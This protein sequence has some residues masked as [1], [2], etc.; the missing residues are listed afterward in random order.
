LL[1]SIFNEMVTTYQS[2]VQG[3]PKDT[4]S[5]SQDTTKSITP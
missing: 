5:D 2:K 3:K 4:V 1:N